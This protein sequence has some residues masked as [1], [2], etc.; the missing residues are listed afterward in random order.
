MR[1]LILGAGAV[2]L[3]VG[4][5]LAHAGHQVTFVARGLTLEALR[6]Q[7]LTLTFG[8]QSLRL[9]HLTVTP[10]V[11]AAFRDLPPYDLVCLTVKA[12]DAAGAAEELRAAWPHPIPVVTFQNGVGSQEAVIHIL[13]G[14]SVIVGTLTTPVAMPA[15]ATVE[16]GGGSRRGIGLALTCLLAGTLQP[17]VR[18]NASGQTRHT[19]PPQSLRPIVQAFREAGFPTRIYN[20]DRA[21]LWSKLLLNLPANAT[22]AILDMTPGQVYADSRLFRLEHRA[23]REALMVMRALGV[24]MVNLPGYPVRLLAP[25]LPELPSVV[26]QPALR[27]LVAGGRGG[28]M[29]SMHLDL[30]R[31]KG[32]TEVSY[33]NGAVVRF[34]REA[35]VSAPV[36]Q[37]LTEV[38]E[39][40]AAGR[41]A[42]DDFRRRPERLLAMIVP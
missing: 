39:E 22:C 15:P 6:I 9:R 34:G 40:L 37:V 4:G 10:E 41:L 30:F 29:P 33:L 23:I 16:A 13:G 27:R 32:K 12:Y 28:K 19:H 14:S 21:M 17:D 24:G 1:V 42:W 2:G 11:G 20:D 7:G 38:L 3:W 18:R 31:G 25:W 35:G 26:L 36:N 8:D 5:R